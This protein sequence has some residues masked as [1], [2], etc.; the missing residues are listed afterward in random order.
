MS[1]RRVQHNPVEDALRKARLRNLRLRKQ[2]QKF[3]K[4]KKKGKPWH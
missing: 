4:L 2:R 1:K 3:L